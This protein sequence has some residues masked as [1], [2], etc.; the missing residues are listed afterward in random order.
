MAF[1]YAAVTIF[2]GL[3][4]GPILKDMPSAPSDFAT[5]FGGKPTNILIQFYAVFAGFAVF[6]ALV[7]LML[8]FVARVKFWW[9]VIFFALVINTVLGGVFGLIALV[10]L[11]GWV[12][13][14]VRRLYFDPLE[15]VS[16]RD[17]KV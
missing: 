14:P 2:L 6:F 16:I 15:P 13:E 5:G 4:F 10:I 7:N 9:W 11:I 1:T 12:G 8:I 17:Q 3:F